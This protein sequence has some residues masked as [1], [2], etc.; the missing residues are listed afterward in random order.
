MTTNICWGINPYIKNDEIDRKLKVFI[1]KIS[2]SS[3]VK[4]TPAFVHDSAYPFYPILDEE[5]FKWPDEAVREDIDKYLEK[6]ADCELEE[7]VVIK[8]SHRM[9]VSS[10]EVL[11]DFMNSTNQHFALFGSHGKNAL[12]KFLVGSF[13]DKYIYEASTPA[14][15]I[16]AQMNEELLLKNALIPL[17]INKEA[18][19]FAQKLSE[20][21]HLDF[22]EQV[23]LMHCL[24]QDDFEEED[25]KPAVYTAGEYSYVDI[26][27]KAESKS[28]EFLDKLS[29]TFPKGAARSITS[30]TRDPSKEI[31]EQVQEKNIGL[32]IIKP[33]KSR[34][35]TFL[36]RNVSYYLIRNA[37]SALLVYPFKEK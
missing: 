12:K 4:I 2:E 5:S 17:E 30:I 27:Y 13:V 35:S 7:P 10:I 29:E 28:K 21:K 36:T 8:N 6:F 37:S 19:E 32:T 25:W 23:E 20:L 9:S 31:L 1:K 24:I 33:I 11:E 26:I 3:D 15:V 18:E 34:L 22:I 16:N 14:F